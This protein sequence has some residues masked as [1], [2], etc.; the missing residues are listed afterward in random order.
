MII[1]S[2]PLS[3]DF[4]E[5]FESWVYGRGFPKLTGFVAASDSAI[6]ISIENSTSSDHTFTVPLDISW[7]EDGQRHVTRRMLSPGSNEISIACKEQP[8]DV[9]VEGLQRL[10]GWHRVVVK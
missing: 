4:G 8:H 2:R 9:R 3:V 10:L 5:F 1:I 7:E 6:E